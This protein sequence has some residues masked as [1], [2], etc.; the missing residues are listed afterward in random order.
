MDATQPSSRSLVEKVTAWA[1]SLKPVR[2]WF[3]YVERRGPMLSDSVTYRA[4]FSVFA[5]VLLGFSFAALWLSGNPQ[6][7]DALV[8][9]VDAAIPGLLQV[10]GSDGL[11]DVTTITAPEALTITGIL[12]LLGLVGAAIGA[13]GSLRAALRTLAD[14]IHDDAFFL[15]VILRNLLLAVAIGGGFVLS[16]AVTVYGS[17]FIETLGDWFDAGSAVADFAT[18]ALAIVVVFV[19]DA[20]LIA[21]AFVVLSG[22]K[23][24]P[25]RVITGALI[26]GAGLIVLQQ[27]S[28]L[29]VRGAGSNPLL[30][31]FA[32][33][34][35]LLLWFNLS[36]QVILLA[37]TW[38]IVGVAEDTDRVREKY[39]TPT[40]EARR[41]KRAE[42]A[43]RVATREL[44]AAQTAA[45]KARTP[46]DPKDE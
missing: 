14:D 43:V 24:R 28:G 10:D 26:G 35:A 44:A 20:G 30:A 23:A 40:F 34:I 7:W 32:A 12:S 36:A 5:A 6:A 8:E 17:T 2:V 25:G 22:V 11:I 37:S 33:L 39:G 31:S 15:W 18:Q 46:D 42:D 3:H 41:V 38:I 29:F 19:L 4:L 13:I 1:L 16:A 45:A 27:L 9:A 21:L